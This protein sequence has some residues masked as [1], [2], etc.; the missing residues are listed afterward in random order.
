M[1]LNAEFN[2]SA[3]ST[4]SNFVFWVRKYLRM[5]F[6]RGNYPIAGES[7]IKFGKNADPRGCAR[8]LAK[9]PRYVLLSGKVGAA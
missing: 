8:P 2:M 5:A 9:R 3:A 1:I 6:S 4:V 7:R